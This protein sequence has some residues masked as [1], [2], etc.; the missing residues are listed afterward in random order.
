[1]LK[2][3]LLN[4]NLTE[5]NTEMSINFSMH[6]GRGFCRKACDCTAYA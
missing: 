1:M 5:V 4:T 3:L 6:K 2:H